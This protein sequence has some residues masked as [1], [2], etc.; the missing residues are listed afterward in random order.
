MLVSPVMERLRRYGRPRSRNVCCPRG[1]RLRC[2]RPSF[3]VL[4][5]GPAPEDGAARC[6]S[7]PHDGRGTPAEE[8]AGE[9][10][11]VEV[12]GFG[13]SGN[14]VANGAGGDRTKGAR[15][16]LFRTS[17]DPP[18]ETPPLSF[19]GE[20]DYSV[21]RRALASSIVE[22]RLKTALP[23][24]NRNVFAPAIWRRSF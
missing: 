8:N 7:S 17:Y 6:R 21:S 1:R 24:L 23:N 2:T 22:E 4:C 3:A 20:W 14:R 11:G 16:V 12:A 18:W 19:L 9:S 13:G 5:A 10:L 15:D